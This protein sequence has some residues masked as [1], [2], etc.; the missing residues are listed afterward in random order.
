MFGKLGIHEEKN[1]YFREGGWRYI[2]NKLK[3]SD[4]TI[5]FWDEERVIED[6]D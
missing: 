6:K 5:Q 4:K 2:M 1:Y 3:I